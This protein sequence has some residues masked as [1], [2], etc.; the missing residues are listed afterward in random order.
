MT[1]CDLCGKKNNFS[2]IEDLTVKIF[3]SSTHIDLIF[4]RK[5]VEVA[6]N[7]MPEQHV[8]ME[9]FG[10]QPDTSKNVALKELETSD[11]LIGVYAY[12]YG[13]IPKGD[14]KSVTEQ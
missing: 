6:I 1:L 12:R 3:I 5:A 9:Y 2:V 7:R 14:S 4:Y 10:S 8:M 11:I 13:T